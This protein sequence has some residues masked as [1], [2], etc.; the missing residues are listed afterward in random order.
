M[1]KI[2]LDAD[3]LEVLSF[4]TAETTGVRGTVDAAETGNPCYETVGYYQ[5]MCLAYPVSYWNEDT[6][7]CPLE[8]VTNDPGCAIDTADPTCLPGC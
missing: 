2:R 1:K 4:T 3:D 6:C 8:P 7:H 5:T